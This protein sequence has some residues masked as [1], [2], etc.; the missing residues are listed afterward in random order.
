M[1]KFLLLLTLTIFLAPH[2]T[3]KMIRVEAGSDFSTANPPSTWKVYVAEDTK[4]KSGQVIKAGAAF[5]GTITDVVS[6]KRLKRDASFVFTPI[7]FYDIHGNK[8]EIKYNVKAKYNFVAKLKAKEVAKKGVLTAGNFVIPG[9][10]YAVQTAEG[11]Y[12]NEK[13]NRIKSG[14]TAL[15]DSTPISLYKEGRE[16]EFKK[17]DVFK[18]SFKLGDEDDNSDEE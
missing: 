9:L 16:I 12:K 10:G 15:V 8:Y 3:A 7:N 4:L 14:A 13:D 18:M 17:G 1:K 5:E 2:A 11:V 6:P